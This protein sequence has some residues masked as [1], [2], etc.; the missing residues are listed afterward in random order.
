MKHLEIRNL[1]MFNQRVVDPLAVLCP[2]ASP[3]K[4][5]TRPFYTVAVVSRTDGELKRIVLILFKCVDYKM[6]G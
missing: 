2:C 1:R 5:N 3:I 6:R 4:S